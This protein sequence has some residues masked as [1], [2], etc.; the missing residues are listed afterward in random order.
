MARTVTLRAA[1]RFVIELAIGQALAWGITAMVM[2]TMFYFGPWA[3]PPYID[4]LLQVLIWLA[5]AIVVGRA[6][7]RY[8]RSR[9]PAQP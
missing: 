9:V 1:L 5:V 2:L 6:I 7:I 3:D 4:E 8:R